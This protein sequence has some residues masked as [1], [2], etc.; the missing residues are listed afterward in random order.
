MKK[1]GKAGPVPFKAKVEPGDVA[2]DKLFGEALTVEVDGEEYH[3]N[4]VRLED[5]SAVYA[6]IRDNRNNSLLR[7]Q[8]RCK[9]HILAQALACAAAIDPT[10]EDYWAYAQTPV[11]ATYIFWRCMA[12]NHPGITEKDVAVLLEKQDG[13]LAMLFAESGLFKPSG[14]PGPDQEGEN[15]DPLANKPVFGANQRDAGKITQDGS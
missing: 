1:H 13:I 12:E 15:C 6:R 11:G 8:N 4:R 14:A 3:I 5:I 10:A 7:L 2:P 9:D